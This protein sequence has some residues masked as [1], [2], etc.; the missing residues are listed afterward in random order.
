M[1]FTSY[2][3]DYLLYLYL[4]GSQSGKDIMGSGCSAEIGASDRSE[5]LVCSRTIVPISVLFF[6]RYRGH[7]PFCI[8][9][10]DLK[11]KALLTS[12]REGCLLRMG[13][14]AS[15]CITSESQIQRKEKRPTL[16]HSLQHQKIVLAEISE[17]SQL[18]RNF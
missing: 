11:R 10:D 17:L 9:A 6:N 13:L 18:S 14:E 16:I 5:F 12:E 4:L 1:F 8:S 2:G 3:I 15:Q 7:Q